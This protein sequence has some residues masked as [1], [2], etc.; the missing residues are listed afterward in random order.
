[1]RKL[2]TIALFITLPALSSIAQDAEGCKDHPMFNRMPNYTISDCSVNFD[3]VLITMADG[4]EEPVA[5]NKTFVNYSPD[6]SNQ[7]PPSFFQIVKNYENAISKYGG[8]MVY[9]TPEK[10]TLKLRS[11]NKDIWLALNSYAS[12]NGAGYY[13]I[14]IVEVEE[15]K[16][17]ILAKDIL[18]ALNNEGHIALYINFETAKSAISAESQTTIG[19]IAAMLSENP[20]LKISIEGHTDNTGNPTSNKLLSQNRAKAVMDALIEKGIASS[21][22]SS[23]GWGQEKPVADNTTPDGKAKNRRVEIVKQP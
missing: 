15:M 3:Q 19:N 7:H 14:T 16:Q 6:E 17:E 8:K 12:T 21:R 4:N 13:D 10:A 20:S 23:K 11:G 22:L 2:L 5:G 18:D 1:M 9:S